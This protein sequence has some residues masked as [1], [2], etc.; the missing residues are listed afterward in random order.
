MRSPPLLFSPSSSSLSASSP[1]HRLHLLPHSASPPSPV[2]SSSF[3]SSSASSPAVQ[4]LLPSSPS[5]QWLRRPSLTSSTEH[6]SPSRRWRPTAPSSTSFHAPFG[7]LAWLAH[8]LRHTSS[9]CGPVGCCALAAALLLL[10]ALTWLLLASSSVSCGSSLSTS[11]WCLLSATLARSP[12]PFS[13]LASPTDAATDAAAVRHD[14]VQL[15]SAF[16]SACTSTSSCPFHSLRHL[17]VVAGHAVL[18]SLDYHNLTDDGQWELQSFQRG[19]LST[20]LRHIEEG[21]ALAAADP[22]ALLLF[23]GGETRGH[24]GPRSEAQS[25]WMVAEL[26]HWFGRQQGREWEEGV[27]VASSGGAADGDSVW[28]VRSRTSTE[29]FARDSYENLLF[30]LCRF[31]ELTMH[32]PQRITVVGFTFKGP[33][34]AELH[35]RAVRFP[36]SNFAY[37]GIDPLTSS[38]TSAHVAE[39]ERLNSFLPFSADPYGCLPPLSSKRLQRNPFRRSHGYGHQSSCPH[40]HALIHHCGPEPFALPLPWDEEGGTGQA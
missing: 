25:Y 6:P 23:S 11:G 18:T 15:Q 21:I 10:A 16:A 12:F 14:D 37:V 29:E 22:A 1:E 31:H 13:P 4:P 3:S 17:V 40:L 26:T 28:S 32:Y 20:F 5:L 7:H 2:P 33:R 35:R 8:A 24:A 38:S 27:D 19:Q 34:F 39:Q 30:S 9:P 36:A